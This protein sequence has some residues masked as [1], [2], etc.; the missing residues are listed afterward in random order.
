MK[1]LK[2]VSG[3]AQRNP[4]KYKYP[5]GVGLQEKERQH[6]HSFDK[7]RLWMTGRIFVREKKGSRQREKWRK[8][9]KKR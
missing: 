8:G 9:R 3:Y 4:E 1:Y 2:N 7:T 5:E 6:F